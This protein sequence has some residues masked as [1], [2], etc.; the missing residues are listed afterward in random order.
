[1]EVSCTLTSLKDIWRCV[2]CL[3]ISVCVF[4]RSV[5]FLQGEAIPQCRWGLNRTTGTPVQ[6]PWLRVKPIRTSF[7]VWLPRWTVLH[8]STLEHSGLE[9]LTPALLQ[10]LG[11]VQILSGL[12]FWAADQEIQKAESFNPRIS[13]LILL[14]SWGPWT[15]L[16]HRLIS[17]SR[18]GMMRTVWDVRQS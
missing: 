6:F 17:I 7:M 8:F 16:W 18:H 5:L 3:R 12:R 2:W 10:T 15:V 1:M 13:M 4:R 9:W 11:S 14:S